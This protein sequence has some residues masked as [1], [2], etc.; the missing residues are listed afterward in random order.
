VEIER[1]EFPPAREV[2][3]G[4]AEKPLK[5]YDGTITVTVWLRTKPNASGSELLTLRLRY[6]A[7][8][9]KR[10]LMPTESDLRI[11]VNVAP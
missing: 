9:E 4:F 3:L 5:V 11:T 8:D 2:R 6:Q 10:C 1:V 7:C